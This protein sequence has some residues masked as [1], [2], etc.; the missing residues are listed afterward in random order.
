MADTSQ[1]KFCPVTGHELV[2]KEIE[3]K[4][5]RVCEHCGFVL[6]Q[7]PKVAGAVFIVRDGAV[8]LIKRSNEPQEGK[9]ALPAGYI[10][11]GEDPREAALREVNEETGITAEITRLVDVLPP[12][13]GQATLLILFEGRPV[14]GA[15]AAQDDAEDVAFF[16][17]DKIPL[18]DI[19]FESTR[20]MIERWLNQ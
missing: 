7:Q 5:R 13:G 17:P 8:L 3:G 18:E 20:V 14:G 11:E 2:E 4:Q 9:W 1:F 15:L 16:P 19:A 6:Y 12:E 10:D